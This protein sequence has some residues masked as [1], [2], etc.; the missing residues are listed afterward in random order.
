[1]ANNTVRN[2]TGVGIYVRSVN[3]AEISVT[4]MDNNTVENP[5]FAGIV[6]EATNDSTIRVN[7]MRGNR[8]DGLNRLIDPADNA[9]TG[10]GIGFFADD[11]AT[12]VTTNV[13]ENRIAETTPLARGTGAGNTDA[14]HGFRVYEDGAG[15][16]ASIA[17]SGQD[18]VVNWDG[19]AAAPEDGG[20]SVF[21][22]GDT[23][24][25][26]AGGF[27]VNNASAIFNTDPYRLD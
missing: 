21:A 27:E 10:A 20:N 14:Q 7:S 2:T 8:V 5:N 24:A 12:I 25:A 22:T 6:Y 17:I 15:A 13:S 19:P 18:N 26:G 16:G 1:V 11:N 4:Q 23:I 9:S 3:D